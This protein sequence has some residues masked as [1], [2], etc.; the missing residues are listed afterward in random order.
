[1][2]RPEKI[3]IRGVNWLGDAVMTTPAL[4]RLRAARPHAHIT[5]LTHEKL[6]ELWRGHPSIDATISFAASESVFGVA[7]RLRREPFDIA[8]VFPNSPRSALEVFL[9]GIPQRIGCARNGRSLLLTR[10]LPPRASALRMHKRSRTEIEQRIA[11][12]TARETFPSAAH[13]VHDYLDVVSALGAN[14][15][16]LPPLLRVSDAEVAAICS[17]F[18]WSNDQPLFALNPGAEY[19]P[20]KRWPA[21]R[22]V[23]TAVRLHERAQC[24]WVIVGGSADR[25]LAG[26]IAARM[27]ARIGSTNITSVAG[28]TSLR[29][30]CAVLKA[31][32]LLVT[33]DTG[34]MHVGAAL[35]TPVV[36]LFG[37]TSPELTGPVFAPGFPHQLIVGDAPCAPCFLRECPIEFRCMKS[38]SVEQVVEG[39]LHVSQMSFRR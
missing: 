14:P 12:N 29:E 31:C 2:S 28:D 32:A 25:A 17:R 10:A 11:R 36:V 37:S 21:E 3:L 16:L 38:I 39:V 34:P 22:F 35:G 6:A 7:R 1:M 4:Q 19:G 5:L 13:H 30:L 15:A 9:A 18:N 8:V 23:E 27:A 20:A 26:D 24:R 33:N